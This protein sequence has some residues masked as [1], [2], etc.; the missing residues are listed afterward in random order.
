MPLASRMGMGNRVCPFCVAN[1]GIA[2]HLV[3]AS[4]LPAATKQV[5]GELLTVDFS[6]AK[7]A[8]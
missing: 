3:S 2:P 5:C 4:L 7:R 1:L 8:V 6:F